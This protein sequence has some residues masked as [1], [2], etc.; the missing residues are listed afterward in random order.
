MGEY[1]RR[2][3][4]GV[5][6]QALGEGVGGLREE[7]EAL[8]G[9]PRFLLSEVSRLRRCG[10]LEFGYVLVKCPTCGDT[11][12][13]PF[14]CKSRLCPS[15]SARRAHETAVHLVEEVL[16]HVPYRQWTVSFPYAIR[17]RLVKERGLLEELLR[18]TTRLVAAWQRRCARKL[19]AQGRLLT[20][21]VTQVQYWGSALQLSPHFHTLV[22]DGVFVTTEAGV[23]F[24]ALPPPTPD[25][26]ANLVAQLARRV[27]K[28]LRK[29]GLEDTDAQVD[30]GLDALRLESL[31][32]SLA[33][34]NV[35]PAADAEAEVRP[36]HRRVAMADGISLHADTA[37]RV[38][39]RQGL[40]QLCRYGARGPL[41][42]SRLSRRDDGKL[43]YRMKRPVRGRDVLVMTPLQLLKKLAAVTPPRG[44]HLVHFH[45]MFAPA[46]S[47][48]SAVVAYGRPP[49]PA[50]P[51]APQASLPLT[52][53]PFEPRPR[54]PRLDWA[55][56]LRKTFGFAVLHCPCG[57]RRVVLAALTDWAQ[58][59]EE[60]RKRGLEPSLR[61]TAMP[62][63][64]VPRQAELALDLSALPSPRSHS[65]PRLPELALAS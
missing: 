43:S 40:E 13:V 32:Q 37:V 5:L 48:R 16:P 59:D 50:A 17:W 46:A 64:H 29:R 11:T 9:L 4:E 38:N 19:G 15:C 3:R 8:G 35:R 6:H 34:G 58:I 47:H 52:P 22:P 30:D 51:V 65:P 36:H 41:A 44:K 10:L 53:A 57:A 12:E 33:L 56:L 55:T 20:G 26:V 49:P 7:A 24:V 61:P 18:K 31:Q 39:D 28:V 23:D 63:H 60:L 21:A 42:E 14:S 27:K 1:R 54:P 25:E 62:R 45:G 2:A